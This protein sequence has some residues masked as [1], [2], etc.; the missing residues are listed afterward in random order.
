MLQGVQSIF[1]DQCRVGARRQQS[2]DNG[3]V[4]LHDRQDQGRAPGRV[5]RIDRRALLEQALKLL[6]VCGASGLLQRAG[7]PE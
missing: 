2:L 6:Q 7:Q 4:P 3:R 5:R 1:I